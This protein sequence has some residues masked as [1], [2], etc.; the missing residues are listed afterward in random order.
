MIDIHSL[1]FKNVRAIYRKKGGLGY[2]GYKGTGSTQAGDFGH[3]P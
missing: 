2:A 1:L 3:C